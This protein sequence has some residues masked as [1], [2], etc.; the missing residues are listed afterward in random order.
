MNTHSIDVVLVVALAFGVGTSALPV[1]QAAA[2]EIMPNILFIMADDH[3]SQAIG[4]YG[5][6]LASL[7]LTPTIDSLAR[8]GMVMEN[9]FC[10]N[11]ICTPSRATIMTGQSSAV[12]G[13]P[14]LGSP[15]P[16]E[17]QYLAIEM[18]RAGYDTA[19]IGKWHLKDRPDAFN[20]YRVLPGQGLYFGLFSRI[21]G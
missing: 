14:R 4:A 10:Q 13:C 17:R 1:R 2:D 8:E 11:A 20:Y 3:T 16:P 5:G 19:V 12:N 21:R 9:A 6:R 18:N 7:N 15:L